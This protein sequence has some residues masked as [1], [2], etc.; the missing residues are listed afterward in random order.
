MTSATAAIALSSRVVR[1]FVSSTFRDM[2]AE[3]DE[4][5]ERTFPQLRKLCESRGVTWGE[6][7][8]RWGLTDEQK[9]EGQVLPLAWR[10]SIGA[11]PTSSACW[12]STTAGFPTRLPPRSLSRRRGWASCAATPLL[13]LR[14]CTA[15][16]IT[17]Q[18]LSM[19]SSI[20]AA[21]PIWT[22][23]RV[24]SGPRFR[25]LPPRRISHGLEPKRLRGGQRSESR[26]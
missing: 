20:F 19:P 18:W 22:H 11:D 25:S 4:L 12:V 2:Q 16:S 14:F 15:C 17:P 3:R 26:S 6:V 5:V 13:N 21:P 8:L 1:V 10:K 24:S 7:D 23:F 9:A